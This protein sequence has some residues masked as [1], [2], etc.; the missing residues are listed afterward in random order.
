MSELRAAAERVRLDA[1]SGERWTATIAGLALVV[2]L[3]LLDALWDKN[4]PSLVVIGPFL[5]SL[6]ANQRQTAA[7]AV[8]AAASALLSAIVE[9]QRAGRRLLAPRRRRDRGRR[10]RRP[11]RAPARARGPRG[12]DRLAAHRRALQPRRG[13]HRPGRR[14]A[15]PVRQRGGSRDARIR[16]G[17]GAAEH[18]ARA[19]R[20]RRRL[21][22]AR[23]ARRSCPSSYPTTRVARGEDPGPV[24]DPDRQALHR[25]GALAR[26]EGARRQRQPRPHAAG[27]ER[28]RGHHRAQALG[29]RAAAAVPHRRG[30]LVLDRLR[31]DAAGGRGPRRARAGGLVRGQHARPHRRDPPGRG[32]PQ[33]PRQGRVRPQARPAVPEPHERR[34]RLGPGPARRPAAAGAGDPRRAA[35]PRRS[36]TPSCSSW[37]AASACARS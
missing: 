20:R 3:T 21:L 19:A 1:E 28:R 4:F 18:A 16:V 15:A 26:D 22:H 30:A 31:A 5:T 25:R 6:R 7:V 13:G 23:T 29:A 36:T 9:Q 10:D 35:R 33:R 14:A 24:H 32:R 37:C 8:L 11:G 17:R 34:G 27:G 2:G 12:G